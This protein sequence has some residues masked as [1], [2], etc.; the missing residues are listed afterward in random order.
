M[1]PAE[2]PGAVAGEPTAGEPAD[3]PA[4]ETAG[5]LNGEGE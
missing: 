5:V 2:P 1:S 4:G 3:A